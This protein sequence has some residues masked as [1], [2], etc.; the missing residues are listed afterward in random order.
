MAEREG[1][2][3]SIRFPALWIYRNI[4]NLKTIPAADLCNNHWQPL[5]METSYNYHQTKEIIDL[6]ENQ[7]ERMKK[8]EEQFPHIQKFNEVHNEK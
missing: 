1:F 3:P 7:G 4:E 6:L 2:E 5:S 8:F